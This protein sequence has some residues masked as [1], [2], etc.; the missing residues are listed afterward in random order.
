MQDWDY[1]DVSLAKHEHL[2]RMLIWDLKTIH[3]GE[4][5]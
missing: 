4:T 1:M 5:D 2:A 3:I